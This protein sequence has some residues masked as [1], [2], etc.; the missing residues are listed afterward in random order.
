MILKGFSG[1]LEGA[2]E[3]GVSIFPMKWG[4]MG[5]Y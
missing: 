2:K 3:I 4:E 1:D 5:S